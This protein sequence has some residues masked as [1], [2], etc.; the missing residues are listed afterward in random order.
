MWKQTLLQVIV[1]LMPVFTF[2]LWY[3]RSKT[4]KYIPFVFGFLCFVA[5]V[6]SY[7]A[8]SN[9]EY[10]H[11]D[12][13]LVPLLVG[14]LYGGFYVTVTLVLTYVALQLVTGYGAWTWVE[15]GGVLLIMLPVL[16]KAIRPFQQADREG[17][18][19]LA[20][21]AAA[22]MMLIEFVVFL[23]YQYV[24]RPDT[25]P[26]SLYLFMHSGFYF[27]TTWVIVF[28][29][30]NFREKQTLHEK[31]EMI[32]N[33]YR[34]EVQKMQQFIDKTPLGVLFTDQHGMITHINEMA[35]TTLQ[36]SLSGKERDE[37]LGMPYTVLNEGMEHSPLSKQL[38]QALNG[39]QT[40]SEII[41]GQGK[42]YMQTGICVRDMLNQNIIG[43]AIISHD[44]SELNRLRDEVGRM[45]RLSLVGQMAASITHEIRNPMAVIRGFIQL[46]RE[47]SPEHQ[48]EYFRIV[49]EELDRANGIINDFLS[50]A[51]NRIIEK[52][53]CSLHDIIHD[54][55][56]LLLADANMRGQTIELK[57]DEYMPRLMLNAKEMKQLILNLARNGMEAMDHTGILKIC[58]QVTSDH[59][60]LRVIDE[61]CGIPKEQLE[62]LFE[63]FYTTKARGTG[64]G[65]PLCLSIVERHGGQIRV[66]SVESIGTAFIVTFNRYADL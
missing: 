25:T 57:L 41:L 64:L 5:M 59:V 16:L 1:A 50:L 44:I 63:P 3:E 55:M 27:L 23:S 15:I 24:E 34:L 60:E 33:N 13:C 6:V 14:S 45:E 30:E 53:S 37:L 29:V 65:L 26:L 12:Y 2:Q 4:R 43:A 58:T 48:Q 32:S 11:V 38:N 56:P 39:F 20:L 8:C 36:H 7:A 35:F 62:R 66:E 52:E 42:I 19:R 40:S 18:Q 46:M 61:G 21:G 51:Q 49:M 31:L 17:R 22:V 54:L 10:F 9:S 47:R 28:L